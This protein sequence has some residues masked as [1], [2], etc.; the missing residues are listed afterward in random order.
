MKAIPV[1]VVPVM[2]E[3]KS[4]P[5]ELTFM[6]FCTTLLCVARAADGLSHNCRLADADKHCCRL[7]LHSPWQRPAGTGRR[8]SQALIALYINDPNYEV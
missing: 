1:T 4:F 2:K 5:T 6:L 7:V 8:L 3:E